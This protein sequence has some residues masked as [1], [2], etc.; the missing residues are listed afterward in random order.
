MSPGL[1][2]GPRAPAL[3]QTLLFMRRSMGTFGKLHAK[4]GDTFTMR[5]LPGPRNVVI[6]SRPEDIKEVFAG[7]PADF[8]AGEGNAILRPV[9]GK[10]SVL[11]TDEDEHMQ[12][13]KLLMPAFNGASL[14]GYRSLVESIAKNE[15]DGWSDGETLTTLDRMNALTLEIILQVVFG[16]TDEAML[17]AATPSILSTATTFCPGSCGPA[18]ARTRT[19]SHSAMLSFAT[20]SSRSCWLATRQRRLRFRGCCTSS[21]GISTCKPKRT[22]L[23]MRATTHSS[24]HASRKLCAYTQSST[25]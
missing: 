14:R 3:F 18:E 7:D 17:S 13:R 23:P 4:Y 11:L 9:M 1:P 16:V 21:A 20:N 24:K 2:A 22:K 8:H 10:H 12:A 25:S 5:I 15:V 19:W 6:F